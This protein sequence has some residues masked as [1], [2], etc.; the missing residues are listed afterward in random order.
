MNI[1]K[2]KE[3]ISLLRDK[4]WFDKTTGLLAIMFIAIASFLAVLGI[5]LENE[6]KNS[7]ELVRKVHSGELELHCTTSGDWRMVKVP[8]NAPTNFVNHKWW[9][10]SNINGDTPTCITRLPSKKVY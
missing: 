7:Q 9:F 1:N 5:N 6:T 10:G 3:N 8:A 4:W 2:I